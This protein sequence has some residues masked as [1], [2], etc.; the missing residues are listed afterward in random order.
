MKSLERIKTLEELQNICVL[1]IDVW[2]LS[3]RLSHIRIRAFH[4]PWKLKNPELKS[5]EFG[6]ELGSIIIQHQH[7]KI[8]GIEDAP[9]KGNIPY[10]NPVS[11]LFN[12]KEEAEIWSTHL[13]E[14]LLS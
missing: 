2:V 13:K 8:W 6:P 4:D 3:A 5:G 1:G 11:Y 7:V 14:Q 12:S 10:A 9:E